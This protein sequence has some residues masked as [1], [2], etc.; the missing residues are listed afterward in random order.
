MSLKFSTIILLNE[1]FFQV[2]LDICELENVGVVLRFC[3]FECL[4]GQQPSIE[5]VQTFV[6]S[7]E[8]QLVILRATLQHKDTFTKLVDSSPVLKL[9]DLPEWAGM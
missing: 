1:C 4:N 6:H 8:Q 3:P 2:P 5:D 9:V 7:L